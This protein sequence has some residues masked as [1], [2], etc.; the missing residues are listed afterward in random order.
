[1]I[2]P[3]TPDRPTMWTRLSL[4][5]DISSRYEN[6]EYTYIELHSLTLDPKLERRDI[7]IKNAYYKGRQYLKISFNFSLPANILWDCDE[8]FRY[9]PRFHFRRSCFCTQCLQLV[10]EGTLTSTSFDQ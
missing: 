9:L 2:I 5:K 1:M 7:P 4:H 3:E 10:L 8:D 6:Y